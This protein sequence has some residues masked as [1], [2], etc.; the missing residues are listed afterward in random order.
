M[1][2]ITSGFSADTEE[3]NPFARGAYIHAQMSFAVRVDLSM[4]LSVLE[5]KDENF[6]AVWVQFYLLSIDRY[7]VRVAQILCVK[8]I[9]K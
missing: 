8:L 9:V 3:S 1:S 4:C 6:P 5:M 7:S 2:R